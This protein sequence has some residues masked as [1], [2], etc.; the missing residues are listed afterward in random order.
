[1]D[2]KDKKIK[3]S[4]LLML[5]CWLIYA[6]SYVGKVNY[7][8]NIN[9]VMDAY[10]V[11]H[12]SAGLVSTFFFFAYGIGQ[13]FNGLFC[14]RYNLKWMI[15]SSLTVSGVVNLTVGLTNNFQLIKFLWLLNGLSM[16][17]LWPSLIRLLSETLDKSLMPKASLIMGTTVATGTFLVY[18][19]SALFVKINFKLSF[20]L[21]AG[22]FLSVAIIWVLT[23]SNLISKVKSEEK[24]EEI[25]PLKTENTVHS[26]YNKAVLLLSICTLSVYGV[27]T[28]LIKDGLTTWVPSILKEQYQLD[29]SISII[30][31]LALPVVSMFAN[32]FAIN[33]HKKIPDFVL[34]C[35][36]MFL[37]SGGIMGGVIAGISLNQFIITLIGFTLV[38]FLVSSSNSLITSIFPLFMKGK[39]NSGLIAGVLNGFCYL[40]STVSSYGLGIIADN[41]GWSAV[42]WTLFSVCGVVCCIAMIY[43]LFKKHFTN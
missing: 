4:T 23:C 19:L 37:I 38:C 6:S 34:Q 31:T 40:G 21:P 10:K 5:L 43:L 9:Q 39:V 3:A 2:V 18:L 15:F 42:F 1:M 17:I 14:K 11:D 36:M 13:V 32:V 25:Q 30:L 24:L 22:I 12:S 16:S 8:A 7:A 41:F 28:N 35:A 33:V 29:S 20:Y 26:N 27:C